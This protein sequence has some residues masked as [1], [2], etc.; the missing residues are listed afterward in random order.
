MRLADWSRE[1]HLSVR[2]LKLKSKLKLKLKLPKSVVGELNFR[3]QES[4]SREGRMPMQVFVKTLTG[5]HIALVVEPTDRID[6][7]KSKIQEKE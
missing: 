4:I 3:R 2:E 7:L 5:K 1:I 6:E